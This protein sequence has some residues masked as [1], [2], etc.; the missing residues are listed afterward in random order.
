PHIPLVDY[1]PDLEALGVDPYP[2]PNRGAMS[3]VIA[4]TRPARGLTGCGGRSAW[5]IPQ[6]FSSARYGMTPEAKAKSRF[7]TPDELRCL[8]WAEIACGA[9]GLIGYAFFELLAMDT[10][11]APTGDK[12]GAMVREPFAARW[13]TVCDGARE[14]R[15][16]IPM[17]LS[18]E[19]CER[20]TSTRMPERTAVWREWGFQGKTWLLMVNT[21][22]TT[23]AAF[24]F[25]FP[26]PVTAATLDLGEAGCLPKANSF[27]ATLPPLGVALVALQF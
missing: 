19:G 10:E 11:A 2:L 17:L 15:D 14:I 21:D 1:M 6:V 23:E 22:D 18:V 13:K 26:K 7:P 20:P 3:R 12:Q 25:I 5:H 4:D 9:N 8:H 27:R 24:E 16:R